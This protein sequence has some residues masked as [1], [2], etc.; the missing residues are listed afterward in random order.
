MLNARMHSGYSLIELLT[1]VAISSLL[2]IAAS[3]MIMNQQRLLSHQIR[4]TQLLLDATQ[5]ANLLR[6]EARRSGYAFTLS[7]AEPAIYH[8]ADQ[9]GFGYQIDGGQFKRVAFKADIPVGKL[10]VC[11]DTLPSPL[12]LESTCHDNI[13]YSL[14]NER[15]VELKALQVL[16]LTN[17]EPL[18]QASLGIG[19]KKDIG[20][21]SEFLTFKVI[22]APRKGE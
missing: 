10:K 2:L 16:K 14:L 11:T 12:P 18:Y 1:T 17:V 20:F 4:D 3:S 6:S 21:D 19:L 8:Q 22:L 15:L 7:G 5:L 13:N 9:V